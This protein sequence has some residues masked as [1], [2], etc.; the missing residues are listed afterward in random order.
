MYDTVKNKIYLLFLIKKYTFIY[1]SMF[2]IIFILDVSTK[3]MAGLHYTLF[4]SVFLDYQDKNNIPH[5]FGR[6]IKWKIR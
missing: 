4:N 3:V 6:E 1:L 2:L 5:H